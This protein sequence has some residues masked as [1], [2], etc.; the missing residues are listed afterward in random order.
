MAYNLGKNVITVTTNFKELRAS[1][2]TKFYIE[3]KKGLDDLVAEILA[4]VV[5]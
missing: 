2:R 4:A 3:Y 5:K 1:A